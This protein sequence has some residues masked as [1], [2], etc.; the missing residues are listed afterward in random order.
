MPLHGNAARAL[1]ASLP[2][3]SG[4]WGPVGVTLREGPRAPLGNE[5]WTFTL[6]LPLFPWGKT[7]SVLWPAV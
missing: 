7:A 6:C 1:V 4:L 5:D 3:R 2:G